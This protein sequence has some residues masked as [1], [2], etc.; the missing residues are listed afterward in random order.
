MVIHKDNDACTAM[1]NAQK[2]TP[3]IQH[4]DI[5]Y[6]LL[7]NWVERDLM[8][9]KLVDT[10]MNMVD[11]FTQSLPR[12]MFHCHAN[13]LL[14]YV[15]PKYSPVYSYLVGTYSDVVIDIETYVP[16]TYMTPMTAAAV[17]ICAPIYHDYVSSSWVIVIW[18]G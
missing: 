9:L 3:H 17:R 1:G 15:P 7:C 10:K 16:S 18:H 13:Y 12:L 8:H 11:M 4:M 6:F 14:G 5:K 2:P